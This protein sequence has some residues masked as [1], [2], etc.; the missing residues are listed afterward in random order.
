MI[1]GYVRDYLP[2]VTLSLPGLDGPLSVEFIVDIGNSMSQEA[3]P[4]KP[5]PIAQF[6]H[7]LGR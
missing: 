3:G 4:G 5:D 1:L 7:A 2:R 6:Q